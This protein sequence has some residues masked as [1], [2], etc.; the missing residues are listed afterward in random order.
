[1]D[2]IKKDGQFYLKWNI[3]PPSKVSVIVSS[4]QA[5]VYIIDKK[6]LSFVNEEIQ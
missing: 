6:S 3:N 5:K 1:M 2:E 4:P